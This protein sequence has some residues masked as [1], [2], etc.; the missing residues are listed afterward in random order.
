MKNQW[1]SLSASRLLWLVLL[2]TGN[3]VATAG[4][5]SY[6]QPES[7]ASLWQK[8][9]TWVQQLPL[10]TQTAPHFHWIKTPQLHDEPQQYTVALSGGFRRAEKSPHH[11]VSSDVSSILPT[12]SGHSS[13]VSGVE[14]NLVL[15]VS[16]P[17]ELALVD[18]EIVWHIQGL[19]QA[20]EHRLYGRKIGLTLPDGNYRINLTIGAYVENSTVAVRHGKLA[21]ATFNPRIGRLQGQSAPLATWEVFAVKAGAPARKIMMRERVSQFQ[22]LVPEGEYDV[23]ATIGDARQLARVRV[24]NGANATTHMDVPTGRINL[25]ATLDNTLAMRPMSWKVFRLDGVTGRREVASPERHSVS[26]L[27]PPGHYEAVAILNGKQRSREFTVRSGTFN[28][29]V[30]AMD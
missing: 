12:M 14:Q 19:D 1:Y 24:N 9:S 28:N 11:D 6:Q 26:L 20:L 21:V 16:L 23:F 30:I 3:V 5:V 13:A 2:I 8:V 25:L 10:S 22:T 27:V 29:I 15:N 7:P 4:T 18:P 17:N